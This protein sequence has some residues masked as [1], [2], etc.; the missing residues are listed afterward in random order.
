MNRTVY[1]RL[2]IIATIALI[3]CS[4]DMVISSHIFNEDASMPDVMDVNIP[5][6]FVEQIQD[7]SVI[8]RHIPSLMEA[9]PFSCDS[10][11]LNHF[12]LDFSCVAQH[13]SCLAGCVNN[14][15]IN[16]QSCSNDCNNAGK[17]CISD[18]VISCNQCLNGHSCHNNGHV[19]IEVCGAY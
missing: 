3:S 2:I 14:P 4:V 8:D 13:N 19:C 12:P 16:W 1:N 18:C 5:D 11:C 15:K 17:T 7:S 10:T 9:G 6:T